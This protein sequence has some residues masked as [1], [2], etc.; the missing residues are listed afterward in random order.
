MVD[1]NG[2]T[3]QVGDLAICH[4]WQTDYLVT[5][6]KIINDKCFLI[7]HG[8]CTVSLFD[9]SNLERISAERVAIWLLEN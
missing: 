2:T 1:K 3:I 9:S 8:K 6:G 4:P 7:A 5:I